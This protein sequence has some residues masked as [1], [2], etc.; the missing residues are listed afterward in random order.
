MDN[1]YIVQTSEG[2]KVVTS[3]TC[4]CMFC[5]SMSLPCRH[6]FALRRKLKCPLFD[7][8]M[9]DKRWTSAYYRTTQR[10]F[11][12]SSAQPVLLS[13]LSKEQ[14]RKLNQ[15]EI[16]RKASLMT[17][18]LASVLSEASNVHFSRRMKV[19]GDLI[20]YWKNGEEVAIIEVDDGM[21]LWCV[22]LHNI[23]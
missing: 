1:I 18:E 19:V 2:V 17:S 11:A 16:F 13:T 12:S 7:A 3:M 20:E 5:Q 21:L 15:H 8:D 4:G 10:L 22:V 23:I 9:C 14:K 6:I